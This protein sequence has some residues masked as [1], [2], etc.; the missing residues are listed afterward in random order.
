[1]SRKKIC[2]T[3]KH[4]SHPVTV[5]VTLFGSRDSVGIIKLYKIIR[6][7]PKRHRHMAGRQPGE[8]RGKDYSCAATNQSAT[9]TTRAW[10]GFKSSVASPTVRVLPDS[11][12]VTERISL[13]LWHLV[14]DT[15]LW[16]SRKLIKNYDWHL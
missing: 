13:V 5:N 9:G 16:Q 11:R 1:M 15:L 14:C 12:T 6:V 8:D 7:G 4:H 10:R 2:Q 3:A